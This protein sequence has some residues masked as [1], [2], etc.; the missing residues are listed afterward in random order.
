MKGIIKAILI[1][2]ALVLMGRAA[3]AQEKKPATAKV[4]P[5]T[6]A[7]ARIVV[8]VPSSQPAASLPAVP[9]PAPV[10]PSIKQPQTAAEAGAAAEDMFR[11]LKARRWWAAAA[12][13]IFILLFLCGVFGLWAKIGTF[14]AWVAVGVLSLAAGT[15]AAFHK[16][17]FNWETFYGYL[18]AGPTVAWLRDFFKDVVVAKFREWRQTKKPPA[19]A[20]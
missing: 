19:P 13:G 14:W 4:A 7:G 17:G 15:F 8:V 18:T 9:V 12:G 2:A 6:S 1:A 20:A 10:D 16:G 3:Q 5:G 11:S